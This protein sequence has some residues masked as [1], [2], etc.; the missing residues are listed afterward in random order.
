MV[1]ANSVKSIASHNSKCSIIRG[2]LEVDEK[3]THQLSFYPI[4]QVK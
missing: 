3:S 1:C 4:D 2:S